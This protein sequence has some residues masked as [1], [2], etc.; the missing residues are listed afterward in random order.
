MEELVDNELNKYLRIIGAYD[1][2]FAKWTARTKKI[3]KRYRDD[4]RGQTMNESA[5]FNILW[6]NIQTLRPTV[7]SRLPN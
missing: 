1:N 6:S 5:K 2:E 3:I 4:T 7:Y